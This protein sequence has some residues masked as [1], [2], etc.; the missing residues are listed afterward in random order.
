MVGRY[1]K[2][3]FQYPSQEG[4][5]S[6]IIPV[7]KD[8]IGLRETLESILE[9]NYPKEKYEIIIAND[10]ANREI[11]KLCEEYKAKCIEINP[12]RG[13]YNA[14]NKALEE[15]KGEYIAFTDADVFVSHNWLKVIE[16]CLC[17][18]DYIVG[19][20]EINTKLINSLADD[21]EHATAFPINQR[22]NSGPTVNMAVRRQVIEIVGGFDRRLQSGGDFEFGDRV[23]RSKCKFKKQY[24]RKMNIIHPPR[25]HEMIIKK[26]VRI[27]KGKQDVLKY[28]PQCK[29]FYIEDSILSAVKRTFCFERIGNIARKMTYTH[30]PRLVK[31]CYIWYMEMLQIWLDFYYQNAMKSEI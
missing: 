23:S 3:E 28:H 12:R 8:V 27:F 1:T 10:G 17:K 4:F 26:Y 24:I 11:S 9:S 14:R 19:K 16:E 21:Y 31:W 5:I 20:T 18:K 2:V 15:S 30:Y 13:S 22:S 6:I 7:Y 25:G 29:A